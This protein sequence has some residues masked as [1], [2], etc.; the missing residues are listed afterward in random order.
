[1]NNIQLV[2]RIAIIVFLVEGIIML[3]LSLLDP[4]SS[5]GL[6]AIIDA[7]VLVLIVSPIMSY[8]VIKPY[9]TERK[10][11]ETDL[12][13]SRNTYRT[14]V[15]NLPQ[16]IFHKD[17]NSVYVSCNRQYASDLG[18]APAA[19]VGKSDYDFHP[20]ELAEQY[21]A[22][23]KN[24]ME[25]GEICELQERYVKDGEERFIH[26]VKTPLKD[27]QGKSTGILGI[28]WDI[29]EQKAAEEE[30]QSMEIQLRHAQKLESVGQLA[31]GI[32]HEVNTPTQ[33]VSDN[34]RFLQDAFADYGRLLT[35]HDRLTDAAASGTVPDELVTE[36]RELAKEVNVDYLKEEIPKAVEQS[37]HGLERIA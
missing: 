14:L 37:L 16:R 22:D 9:I 35:V 36:V 27:E 26:T 1:M 5:P 8:W 6:E 3:G 7:F 4:I 20:V 34:T 23:D 29:T 33:L 32:A 21:R 17:T 31:A 30:R 12:R 18:I 15:D 11:L 10:Q 19:L 2:L 28:F 13:K 24:V 25:S